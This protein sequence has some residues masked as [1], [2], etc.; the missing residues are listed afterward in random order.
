[1]WI[2]VLKTKTWEK[3]KISWDWLRSV[4]RW[5]VFRLSYQWLS[6]LNRGQFPLLI[7]QSWFTEEKWCFRVCC[8]SEASSFPPQGA[9]EQGV[10]SCVISPA[11][12]ND[13]WQ[14]ECVAEVIYDVMHCHLLCLYSNYDVNLKPRKYGTSNKIIAAC[15]SCCASR[16]DCIRV[17]RT[18]ANQ[19]TNK[20]K[21][22]VWPLKILSFAQWRRVPIFVFILKISILCV[23]S[24]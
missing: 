11:L 7:Q 18:N 21:W 3:I 23:L 19:R 6:F 15:H 20:Y 9:R 16:G 8:F 2:K 17:Q 14:Q 10:P 5:E 12:D 22:Y 1:M 4:G 24:Y 13:H